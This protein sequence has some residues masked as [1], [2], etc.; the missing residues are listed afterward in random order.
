MALRRTGDSMEPVRNTMVEVDLRHGDI[1]TMEGLCQKHCVHFVP[2]D[3]RFTPPSFAEPSE[4]RSPGEPAVHPRESV[5]INVTFRWIRNHKQRCRLRETQALHGILP[6]FCE[7]ALEPEEATA[8]SSQPPPHAR[9][10]A[11]GRPVLWRSCEGCDHDG[12]RGGRNCLRHEG[13]WLCRRCW[14][15]AQELGRDGL[16]E[17]PTDPAAAAE[18][19]RLR[20]L[21]ALEA[22]GVLGPPATGAGPVDSGE[23]VGGDEG[24]AG[25]RAAPGPAGES[26]YSHWACPQCAE[27]NWAC[28]EACRGCGA[29]RPR[30]PGLAQLLGWPQ[31]QQRRQ[32][33]ASG[34]SAG[35]WPAGGVPPS[36]WQGAAPSAHTGLGGSCDPGWG[37]SGA[38]AVSLYCSAQGHHKSAEEQWREMYFPDG[39]YQ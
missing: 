17:L 38:C 26:L 9:D 1:L 23:A 35:P 24:A 30:G 13:W 19:K 25:V 28:R 2:C 22:K 21:R 4:Q 29:P 14:A 3:A 36:A 31:A 33:P 11:G 5:R 39:V 18:R 20:Q 16:H 6:L 32:Q 8:A 10:W 12:W 7:Q 34:G 27:G 15:R 37:Q